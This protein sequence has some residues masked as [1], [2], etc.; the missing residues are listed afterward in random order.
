MAIGNTLTTFYK[1]VHGSK[2]TTDIY[3]PLSGSATPKK[4]PVGEYRSIPVEF[5]VIQ[6][7]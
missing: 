5:R 4:Y 2:I 1:E 3:L 7:L 6:L